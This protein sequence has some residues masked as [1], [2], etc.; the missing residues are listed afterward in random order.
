M[1]VVYTKQFTRSYKVRVK[2]K[3]KLKKQF[4][5]RMMTFTQDKT[6]LI[7]RVHKLTGEMK[8]FRAFSIYTGDLRAALSLESENE[9]MLIDVGSY[10]K[11]DF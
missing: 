5:A 9:M 2:S 4:E 1:K 8:S 11:A 10:N 6:S 7:S 3:L